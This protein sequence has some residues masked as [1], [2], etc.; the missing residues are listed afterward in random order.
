MASNR[1]YK[2]TVAVRAEVPNL[3]GGYDDMTFLSD[4]RPS[5]YAVDGGDAILCVHDS[6]GSAHHYPVARLY[7]W[8]V[9]EDK[10]A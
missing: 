3:P 5:L 7:T 4:T 10:G 8:R 6:D 9:D 1:K 2:F